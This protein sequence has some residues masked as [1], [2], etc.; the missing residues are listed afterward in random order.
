MGDSI[1][2]ICIPN[3]EFSRPIW[4]DGAPGLLRDLPAA[5]TDL[6]NQVME[7]FQAFYIWINDDEYYERSDISQEEFRN[8]RELVLEM[9]ARMRSHAEGK[10][11]V[12]DSSRMTFPHFVL[13]G[14]GLP[15]Q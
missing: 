12:Y 14:A 4:R 5:D 7:A 3:P 1:F 10:T 15:P 13:E 9:D 2:Y 11:Y 6:H 8:F